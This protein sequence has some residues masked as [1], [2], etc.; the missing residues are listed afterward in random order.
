[1]R[2]HTWADHV[3]HVELLSDDSDISTTTELFLERRFQAEGADVSGNDGRLEVRTQPGSTITAGDVA[4]A[5]AEAGV[6]AHNVHERE[7]WS[8]AEVG[9]L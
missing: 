3:V 7:E 6:R 9:A 8:V 5:L 2:L 4:Q 1:M